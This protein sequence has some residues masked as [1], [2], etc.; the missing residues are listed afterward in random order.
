[1]RR[2]VR[3]LCMAI[4]A[5]LGTGCSQR[6]A[7]LTHDAYIW[8]RQWTS[9]LRDAVAGSSDLVRAWRVLVAQADADGT[10]GSFGVDRDALSR[11]GRPVVI[12]IRIDGRLATFDEAALIARIADVTQ[13][14][15]SAAGLEID[16]DCPT[17]R[18]PAYAHFLQVMK[19]RLGRTPLSITALPTWL[20]SPDL[21]RLLDVPDEA[22]LRV[23]SVQ[24]PQAGLFSV[25]L[26]M[27]WVDDFSRRIRKP[28][29]VALPTYGSRDQ[30]FHY[31]Y[32]AAEHAAAAADLLPPRSQAFAATL[33][34]PTHWVEEGPP[35]C[36][37]RMVGDGS[38]RISEGQ[39]RAQAYY[40][41]YVKQG[42]YV[43]WA[44]DFGSS[45]EEPDF[46]KAR[47]FKRAQQFQAVKQ[48]VRNML[49]VR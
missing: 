46:A 24:A 1:M 4:F 23:P 33:C 11:S 21:D 31:R 16:Y 18:L 6:A 29:R 44:G 40:A 12:V 20:S 3:W 9:S 37:E 22:V 7:P 27:G 38:V 30:R 47:A 41:R 8:Q 43:D 35:G 48:F 45:C 15:P 2:V 32:V 34:V 5:V 19:A 42:A 36:P 14:W 10:F 49:S 28:F 39:R 13:A 17:R 26:A 25:E